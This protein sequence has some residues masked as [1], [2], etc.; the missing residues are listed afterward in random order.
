MGTNFYLEENN[1]HIGKSSGGWCFALHIHP[2]D[3]INNLEDWKKA[4][5]GKQI[6]N[7]YD[8]YVTEDKMLDIITNRQWNG[9]AVRSDAF[10]RHNHAVMG[11]NNLCR[12]EIDGT[13]CVGYGEGTWDYLIGEFS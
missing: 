9:I 3:G 11:P 1:A 5:A 2:D 4:W 6:V 13:H 8:E 7:E 12:N 10:L